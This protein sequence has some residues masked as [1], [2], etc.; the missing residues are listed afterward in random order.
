[1]LLLHNQNLVLDDFFFIVSC[2]YMCAISPINNCISNIELI[3]EFLVKFWSINICQLYG[4]SY[5]LENLQSIN[6][7]INETANLAFFDHWPG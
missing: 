2:F 3:N 6:L 1:M 7:N 4:L 5:I